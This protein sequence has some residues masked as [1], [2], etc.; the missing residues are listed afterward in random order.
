MWIVAGL[1]ASCELTPG[2][3]GTSTITGKVYIKEVN[4]SGIVTAE[5]FA[6][7]EDVFILFDADSIYDESTKTSFNGEYQFEYMRKGSYRIFAYTDIS[8]LSSENAPVMVEVEITENNQN[9]EAPLIVI[10]KK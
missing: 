10:E 2:E 6:H 4:S 8:S 9:V 7:D 1:L 5:Y 3:G